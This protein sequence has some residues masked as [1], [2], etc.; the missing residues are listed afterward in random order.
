MAVVGRK[1]NRAPPLALP[2]GGSVI[3]IGG[4]PIKLVT[5]VLIFGTIVFEMLL[6]FGTQNVV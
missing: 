5:T 3:L 1:I 2:A 6:I 4:V